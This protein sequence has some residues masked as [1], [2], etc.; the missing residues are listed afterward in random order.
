[1]PHNDKLS[2]DAWV[3]IDALHP[4]PKN[5]KKHDAKSTSLLAAGIRRFGFLVPL[6]V[7]R[8][9]GM[10]AAG[11]G[12]LLAL[13]AI[14]KEAPTFVPANA[15]EGTRPGAVP[16]LWADFETEAQ[17]E[18]FVISDNQHPKNAATDDEA[19]AEM[20]RAMDA[21]GLSLDGIGFSDEALKGLLADLGEEP[22]DGDDDA[23]EVDEAGEPDSVVGWVYELGPHRLV[24]GDSTTGEVIDL[25]LPD[26][27]RVDAVVTS[28]P[29]AVG[30][31]YG[32]YNDT[33][34]ALRALLNIMPATW[35]RVVRPGGF[36]VVNF[37]DLV[38]GRDM[39]GTDEPCEYPMALEYWPAFR[40]AGWVL[41]TRRVWCKPNP[42]CAAPWTASSNRAAADWEHVWTWK[43]PGDALVS[44]QN[45]SN[46]GWI[47]TS[48][49]HGVDVGKGTHG[50]GM[51][52]GAAA[53]LI[54]AHTTQGG[55]VM[56]PFGGTGTTLIASATLGRRC[57]MSELSPRYC[58]VIRRRWT[59]WAREHNRDP[60]P[61]ALEPRGD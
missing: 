45:E 6:T 4:W 42:R 49:M 53:W 59:K 9:D 40:S 32:E 26:S 56:E 8:S 48:A 31:D 30:V 52:V 54:A 29:Y 19:I 55:S 11:H 22:S 1:M 21:D 38:S 17:F 10:I 37:G 35:L 57:F 34:E 25:L 58:D 39:A 27:I 16:V 51:P 14:L 50:A 3:A 41:W 2:P 36:A 20:L 60:G 43:S 33:I 13:Q 5:P 12:R 46:K 18:A 44:R 7:R 28:P 15:P 24:C 61:G 23:P 47:D